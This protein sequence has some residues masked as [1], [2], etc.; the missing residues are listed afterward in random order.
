MP[1]MI[2]HVDA[3]VKIPSGAVIRDFHLETTNQAEAESEFIRCWFVGQFW[4]VRVRKEWAKEEA[5]KMVFQFT[6]G[7]F[8]TTTESKVVSELF[9]SLRTASDRSLDKALGKQSVP[10]VM[11]VLE[12][13]YQE[14]PG[15]SQTHY[16]C[17][18]HTAS[19]YAEHWF[20]EIELVEHPQ[21]KR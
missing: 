8:A 20:N 10:I 3:E 11:T 1:L 12:R 2:Y 16:L 5:N 6:I 13:R 21:L 14:C 17:R 9:E 18:Y 7:Q 15:G 4:D 19:G